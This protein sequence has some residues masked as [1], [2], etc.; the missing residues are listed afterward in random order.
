M[1]DVPMGYELLLNLYSRE[2]GID[3]FTLKQMKTPRDVI[4]LKD[5]I[6]SWCKIES[7]EFMKF[8]DFVKK[9]NVITSSKNDVNFSITTH[10]YKFD[11]GLGGSH[12]CCEAGIYES[13]DDWIILDCDI[14]SLYPSIAKSL[15]LYPQ[16]LGP[17][18]NEI[19]SKFIDQRL[20]EKHKPKNERDN[21][22]IEGFKLILNGT[23]IFKILLIFFDFKN[24]YV[25]LY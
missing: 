1:G 23:K 14:G 15:G 22:L 13:N 12:G 24:L 20:A 5:C 25:Y 6:P 8:L 3:K 4:H 21:V 17:K 9:T 10:N 2:S 11:F 18:F 19:Y 7:K 16:H